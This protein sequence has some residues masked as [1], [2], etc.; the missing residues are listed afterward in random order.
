M[1]RRL[2]N[3]KRS[4]YQRFKHCHYAFSFW[5]VSLQ[6]PFPLRRKSAIAVAGALPPGPRWNLPST[7]GPAVRHDQDGCSL[8]SSVLIEGQLPWP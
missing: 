4:S 2:G 3:Q 6:L 1:I 7:R 8:T 5:V